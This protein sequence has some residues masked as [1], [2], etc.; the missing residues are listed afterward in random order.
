MVNCAIGCMIIGA[1]GCVIGCVAGRALEFEPDTLRK[2][3]KRGGE[4]EEEYLV[5]WKGY[6]SEEDS[7]CL[8]LRGRDQIVPMA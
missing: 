4:E 7:W 1:I 2:K 6:G 8:H 5:H 3:R